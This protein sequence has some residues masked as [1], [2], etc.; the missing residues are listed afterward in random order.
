MDNVADSHRKFTGEKV[1]WDIRR[2]VSL[3]FA[4]YLILALFWNKVKKP[5][6]S[7]LTNEQ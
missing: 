5:C 6:Y 7:N 4:T 1:R 2:F 3:S